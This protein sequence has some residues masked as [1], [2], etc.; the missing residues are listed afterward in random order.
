ML[1][2][3]EAPGIRA[4]D[5]M[6]SFRPGAKAVYVAAQS[7]VRKS[8]P[9]AGSPDDR[10]QHVTYSQVRQGLGRAISQH[11]RF[12]LRSHNS[13]RLLLQLRTAH[14][15]ATGRSRHPHGAAVRVPSAG[16]NYSDANCG[17]WCFWHRLVLRWR[18]TQ[19][20]ILQTSWF[21]R[22]L[23][24]C[25]MGGRNGREGPSVNRLLVDNRVTWPRPE[26]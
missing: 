3:G 21:C 6:R 22:Y 17:W 13:R 10:T 26:L 2:A 16:R 20:S 4:V 1:S 9:A 15:M 11:R 8:D 12:G 18:L 25:S 7:T 5:P 23:I 19:P 24:R 14:E